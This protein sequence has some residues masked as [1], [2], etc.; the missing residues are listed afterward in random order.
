MSIIPIL[1][2]MLP[3]LLLIGIWI[4]FMIQMKKRTPGADAQQAYMTAHLEET[5]RMNQTL[6]RI[7][8][9]L[10]DRRGA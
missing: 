1:I 6:D 9:A 8:V 5:R 10:E 4:F 2:N 7:A 3:I